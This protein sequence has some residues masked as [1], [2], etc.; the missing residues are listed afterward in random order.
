MELMRS[1]TAMQAALWDVIDTSTPEGGLGIKGNLASR[2][3]LAIL[4]A[5]VR[6]L[7]REVAGTEVGEH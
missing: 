2:Q 5:R 7:S 3:M 4:A 6:Q 1:L